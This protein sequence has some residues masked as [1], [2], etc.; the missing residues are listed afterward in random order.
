MKFETKVET[1]TK[2]VSE[3]RSG[4]KVQTSV[5]PAKRVVTSVVRARGIPGITELPP[6]TENLLLRYQTRVQS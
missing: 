1:K 6:L 3:I 4:K 5:L 2:I